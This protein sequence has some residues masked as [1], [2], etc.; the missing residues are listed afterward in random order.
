MPASGCCKSAVKHVCAISDNPVAAASHLVP[1]CV[2]AGK[3]RPALQGWPRGLGRVAGR[4]TGQR[5]VTNCEWAHG[6]PHGYPGSPDSGAQSCITDFC[7][8]APSSP[9]RATAHNPGKGEFFAAATPSPK[10]DMGQVCWPACSS[11]GFGLY[12]DFF[13][14]MGVLLSR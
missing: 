10:L 3:V 8:A 14:Q 9:I 7:A 1:G 6:C 12:F 13:K 11:L 4:V 5:F 2:C